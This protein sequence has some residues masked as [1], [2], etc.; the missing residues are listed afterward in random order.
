LLAPA[1]REIT[2]GTGDK[3]ATLGGDEVLYRYELT[4][5]NQTPLVI[6]VSDNMDDAAFQARVKLIE[7]AEFE[8]TGEKLKLDAIALRNVSGS[9]EKICRNR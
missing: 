4:Y 9:N 7:E 8:R 5:Y 1:V 6:D 2:F 3:T